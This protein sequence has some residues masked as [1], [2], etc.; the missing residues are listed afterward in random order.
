MKKK[1]LAFLASVLLSAGAHAAITAVTVTNRTTTSLTLQWSSDVTESNDSVNYAS[2]TAGVC[3]TLAPVTRTSGCNFQHSYTV[4]GLTQNTVYCLQ[5]FGTKCSGGTDTGGTVQASTLAAPTATA[6]RTSTRTQTPTRTSTSTITETSTVTETSTETPNYTATDTPTVTPT[7]T[8]TSTVTVTS[9]VTPTP[10]AVVTVTSF[11]FIRDGGTITYSGNGVTQTVQLTK[12]P[13]QILNYYL[14]DLTSADIPLTSDDQVIVN[15]ED[16]DYAVAYA[17]PDI[18]VSY[19]NNRN[20]LLY[21]G[22]SGVL[23]TGHSYAL[24][25]QYLYAP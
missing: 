22:G 8:F 4:T 10:T 16:W 13:I 14:I 11:R 6:T 15:S 19:D 7:A 5:P 23:T 21:D 20:F 25:V 17:T 3:N 2:R 18:L 9:T 1:L 12:Q 24:K